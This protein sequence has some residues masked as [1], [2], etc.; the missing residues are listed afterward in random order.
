MSFSQK[1]YFDLIKIEYAKLCDLIILEINKDNL[2][3]L[4]MSK[5]ITN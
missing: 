1:Q 4:R 2:Y 3:M 5:V